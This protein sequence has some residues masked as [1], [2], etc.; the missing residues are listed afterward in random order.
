MADVK[1]RIFIKYFYIILSLGSSFFLQMI[2]LNQGNP[3]EYSFKMKGKIALHDG[4]IVYL[5]LHTTVG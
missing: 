2:S 3:H 5:V 1:I 4:G